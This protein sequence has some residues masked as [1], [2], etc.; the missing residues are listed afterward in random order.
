MA[1]IPKLN[2]Y[3]V[4]SGGGWGLGDN[5]S[6]IPPAEMQ[7]QANRPAY[8]VAHGAS[9]A[10][11]DHPHTSD[12]DDDRTVVDNE[13]PAHAMSA[14][15]G[16][17]SATLSNNVHDEVFDLNDD[18]NGG[19]P[20]PTVH[21]PRALST[22][23]T[24][25][26]IPEQPPVEADGSEA[27]SDG[28][29]VDYG[30]ANNTANTNPA[31]VTPPRARSAQ[32]PAPK[33]VARSLA[34]TK[35]MP[36][37]QQ[38][39]LAARPNQNA[40]PSAAYDDEV[41]DG[42][43][44]ARRK[45]QPGEIVSTLELQ[46]PV[47]ALEIINGKV[48]TATGDEPLCCYG[49][50]GCELDEVHVIESVTKIRSLCF[51]PE[52]T[53]SVSPSASP[54]VSAPRRQHQGQQP[55]AGSGGD[56]LWCGTDEGKIIVVNL[57]FQREEAT[58]PTAHSAAVTHLVR[59]PDGRVWSAGRDKI[60]RL[61]DASSRR[62]LKWHALHTAARE[63]CMIWSTNQLWTFGAQDKVL[64]V[65]DARDGREA[66]NVKV[67]P[68]TPA[69]VRRGARAG[70][71][72]GSNPGS[73]SI[74]PAAGDGS[75]ST[76]GINHEVI[77][78]RYH[79][80][81]GSVWVCMF[82]RLVVVAPK[83]TSGGT[84]V[85]QVQELA[86]T[87]PNV[88]FLDDNHVVVVGRGELVQGQD[89]FDYV[90]VFRLGATATATPTLISRGSKLDGVS[91]VGCRYLGRGSSF[92]VVA[93]TS[94]R[95]TR[96]LSV[97][98]TETMDQM[99]YWRI[100]GHG[101]RVRTAAKTSQKG[102]SGVTQESFAVRDS[103]P[104]TSA[105]T[106]PRADTT[107]SGGRAR[108]GKLSK[109]SSSNNPPTGERVN[110]PS[111]QRVRSGANKQE[112]EPTQHATTAVQPHP[113]PAAQRG[114][115]APP[116]E[117]PQRPR[118]PPLPT[119][120]A[121]PPASPHQQPH[122][123][124]TRDTT[125]A[126]VSSGRYAESAASSQVA[127]SA[128]THMTP[129]GTGPLNTGHLMASHR[130]GRIAP[131]LPHDHNTAAEYG[132]GVRTMEALIRVE[133]KLEDSNKQIRRV[134]ISQERVSD[135]NVVLGDTLTLYRKLLQSG[136]NHPGAV[137]TAKALNLVSPL[138]STEALPEISLQRAEEIDQAYAT[139]EGRT[140]AVVMAGL[141]MEINTLRD[142]L[143]AKREECRGQQL[144]IRQLTQQVAQLTQQLQQ[145]AVGTRRG[146]HAPTLSG[147]QQTPG[148][149][150]SPIVPSL[151]HQPS[152]SFAHDDLA[153]SRLRAQ[154]LPSGPSDPSAS[155]PQRQGQKGVAAG[156]APRADS[157]VFSG[158]MSD[159]GAFLRALDT[160]RAADRGLFSDQLKALERQN[161]QAQ[162]KLQAFVLGWTR[163]LGQLEMATAAHPPPLILDAG[164]MAGTTA[165]A[166]V[167]DLFA[168]DSA[169]V[170]QPSSSIDDIH[171]A[172][173]T[174]CA[175][176]RSHV[177]PR[178]PAVG[179]EADQL[180][181]FLD[182][183]PQPF[184]DDEAEET[185]R[186]PRARSSVGGTPAS[187]ALPRSATSDGEH[188][189]ALQSPPPALPWLVVA[190]M[191]MP[192][193]D[194]ASSFAGWLRERLPFLTA[195]GAGHHPTRG[196]D[197]I[198]VHHEGAVATAAS[199]L[200]ASGLLLL[201]AELFAEL[202]AHE[203][204]LVLAEL[205]DL[206][207]ATAAPENPTRDE[208]ETRKDYSALVGVA[209]HNVEE[210]GALTRK[211]L[212]ATTPKSLDTSLVAIG[213]LA[214]SAATSPR[215]EAG[216]TMA[217][218]LFELRRVLTATLFP[219]GHRGLNGFVGW[220]AL[221]SV[222]FA[223][224]LAHVRRSISET[225]AA[226]GFESAAADDNQGPADPRVKAVE[227]EAAAALDRLEGLA[228]LTKWVVFFLALFDG[229]FD[230]E[231]AAAAAA[232]AT[233][234]GGGGDAAPLKS[235]SALEHS[236][237]GSLRDRA[238]DDALLTAS[239]NPFACW[240]RESD[241]VDE[242]LHLVGDQHA[243]VHHT[244]A[245]L[246]N[247]MH[248]LRDS[249]AELRSIVDAFVASSGSA[250]DPSTGESRADLRD[251]LE[252]LGERLA[253]Q[254]SLTKKYNQVVNARPAD[255]ASPVASP[256]AAFDSAVGSAAVSP[257]INLPIEPL[258]PRTRDEPPPAQS[259]EDDF[260]DLTSQTAGQA[261][262]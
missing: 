251:R 123:R 197:R 147:G 190:R 79:P 165:S 161:Q 181:E 238:E 256:A 24:S 67:M 206:M 129:S 82:E 59:A 249:A 1:G 179:V 149:M 103:D 90:S 20:V 10:N 68:Q 27:D 112:S 97:I 202:C 104:A 140:V 162:A 43:V 2:L 16:R 258:P 61:W 41:D 151:G 121:Q 220:A 116:A 109:Q 222:C 152:S 254:Q 127:I 236:L 200:E 39:A 102:Q 62:I 78:L 110:P 205:A 23:V 29:F 71:V 84:I 224:H 209:M 241:D 166:V 242:V 243:T 186:P 75:D 232:A 53:P 159:L 174:V 262:A 153:S 108:S 259:L 92:A 144:Q 160:Q 132:G 9:A 182:G 156:A 120:A 105:H 38:P 234:F 208:A 155:Q 230:D 134:R 128:S 176:L 114:T 133:R 154:L 7:A 93:H 8:M 143:G 77:T 91:A 46:M 115:H 42:N 158:E 244:L 65:W 69:A 52:P 188:Q 111:G 122:H 226:G 12:D 33:S 201:R 219:V 81:T 26:V 199:P 80:P 194:N 117:S 94:M 247:A 98:A 63:V 44:S 58:M 47:R 237:S 210:A 185:S 213:N 96:C 198:L 4:S 30:P 146:G 138:N 255:F 35:T 172:V 57:Y 240:I 204:V 189:T 54:S 193:L 137:Q 49:M 118:F 239:A 124:G 145:A 221:W 45:W 86:I 139:G 25:S 131:P 148:S 50:V 113:Q 88:E 169:V 252:R 22:D 87:A 196:G 72:S 31:G 248:R 215:Y 51:V 55:A 203:A 74:V 136:K 135:L 218:P 245:S 175:L 246:C 106:T 260:S 142:E 76:I 191:A 214:S 64:R 19:H 235:A 89:N 18:G 130:T 37:E 99:G 34:S 40:S 3:T 66:R 101:E 250:A 257:A 184:D 119:P 223:Y 183:P 32:Q 125:P 6:H 216:G 233:S 56:V 170:L 212:S 60:L 13:N 187:V 5:Y 83:Q 180:S 167:A 229:A 70:A 227:A 150:A 253:A 195:S 228:K 207:P 157:G 163:V 73:P 17:P 100:Q 107:T 36:S 141:E 211:T 85:T 178:T 28:T 15:Q 171:T 261:E 217:N 225:V 48:W 168:P 126:G 95:N 11:I 21:V 177:L 164:R 192:Y 173:H 231:A 14:S